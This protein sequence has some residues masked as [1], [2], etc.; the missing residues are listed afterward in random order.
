MI[1]T[2]PS[3]FSDSKITQLAE[4]TSPSYNCFSLPLSFLPLSLPPSLP[5]SFLPPLTDSLSLSMIA[6]S[7]S[8]CL[9]F[10]SNFFICVSTSSATSDLILRSSTFARCYR[11]TRIVYT[12]HVCVGGIL[13]GLYTAHIWD[14]V[15]SY[16]CMYFLGKA[17]F[18]PN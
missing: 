14:I 13:L 2:H 4:S 10:I 6:S 9:S 18:Q 7:S 15:L 3:T 11:K 12:V 8:K 1:N 5:L 16:T 17:C